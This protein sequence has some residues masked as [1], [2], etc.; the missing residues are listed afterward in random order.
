MTKYCYENIFQ[1]LFLLLGR[2]HAHCT[3]MQSNSLSYIILNNNNKKVLNEIIINKLIKIIA[4]HIITRL[5]K[6]IF[7]N[8]CIVFSQFFIAHNTDVRMKNIDTVHN[9]WQ[10][11]EIVF[12]KEKIII[13]VTFIKLI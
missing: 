1:F 10:K 12:P 7:N 8:I 13:L 6:Y 3:V 9:G 5:R 4:K 2:I 11:C